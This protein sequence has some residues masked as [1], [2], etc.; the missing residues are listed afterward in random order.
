VVARRAAAS[1]SLRLTG[2]GFGTGIDM[3]PKVGFGRAVVDL[4]RS[5]PATSTNLCGGAVEE[6]DGKLYVFLR[7][8]RG[9]A[10][11]PDEKADELERRV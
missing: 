5:W 8:V 7:N 11:V 10:R 9:V 6:I 1:D 3:S 4:V 2:A